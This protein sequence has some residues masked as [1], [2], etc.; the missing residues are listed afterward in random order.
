MQGAAFGGANMQNWEIRIK[1]DCDT[2][3]SSK[4]DTVEA[5]CKQID[6]VVGALEHL[7]ENACENSDTRADTGIVLRNILT[8]NFL[9]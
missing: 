6:S 8:F 2:R 1:R 5:V 7:Q 9:V 3:W 4:C